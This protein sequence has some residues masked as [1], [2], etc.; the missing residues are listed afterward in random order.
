MPD[1][2]SNCLQKLSAD[3]TIYRTT[4]K[5][6]TVSIGDILL[7]LVCFDALH[8]SQQTFSHVR[9][10]SCLPGL[11]Q[12]WVV[13]K[14]SCSRTQHGD[15][16]GHVA[17]SVTCL[18]ADPRG[19]EFD[20]SPVPYFRGDWDHDIISMAILLPFADSRRVVVSYEWK[21]V[22]EALVKR[23]VKLA[24]EVNWPSWHDHS[25]WLGC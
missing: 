10:I 12:Y 18:T 19:R 8:P 11:N 15:L 5:E 1:L 3:D 4:G 17:Q 21:Y 7:S 23:I 16:L 2:G 6:L 25:C 22:H 20:P 24:Q 14:V 13:D 9:T